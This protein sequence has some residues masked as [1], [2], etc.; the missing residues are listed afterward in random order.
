MLNFY[1]GNCD[2]CKYSKCPGDIV[3]I[4]ERCPVYRE[5]CF[6]ICASDTDGEEDC[7]FYV[8]K[9]PKSNL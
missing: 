7:K 5:D 9:E 2:N 4:G 8:Q 1:K 6:C 3:C